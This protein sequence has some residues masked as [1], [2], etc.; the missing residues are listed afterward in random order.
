MEVFIDSKG[1]MSLNPICSQ[2]WEHEARFASKMK[3]SST[4]LA[5]AGYS[6]FWG[7]INRIVQNQHHWSPPLLF[8]VLGD[9]D[10]NDFGFMVY[11]VAWK[12]MK[13]GFQKLKVIGL[14]KMIKQTIYD[15]RWNG[16]SCVQ[17]EQGG[18]PTIQS[19]SPKLEMFWTFYFWPSVNL[20]KR[21]FVG[22]C[23]RQTKWEWPG[24]VQEP[25]F[26]LAFPKERQTVSNMFVRFTSG[27]H[28]FS[29]IGGHLFNIEHFIFGLGDL[30]W[31]WRAT[32]IKIELSDAT[33]R[34][35]DGYATTT[36]CNKNYNVL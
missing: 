12:P 10:S 16:Q 35:K 20:G 5:K 33:C 31:S 34:R 23:R 14:V 9:L 19:R 13:Y 32:G 6:Y 36:W 24:E 2:E 4:P 17:P 18:L 22:G 25:Y 8:S 27:H 11:L 15:A 29:K 30:E 7:G 3:I 1:P 26:K 21:V 28:S